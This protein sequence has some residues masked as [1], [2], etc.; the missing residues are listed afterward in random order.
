MIIQFYGLL[1][2]RDGKLIGEAAGY[3]LCTADHWKVSLWFEIELEVRV[4][5]RLAIDRLFKA[6]TDLF[7]KKDPNSGDIKLGA[8]YR[9]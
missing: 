3:D 4:G 7:D 1:P 5:A 6:I 8:V 9:C 2:E